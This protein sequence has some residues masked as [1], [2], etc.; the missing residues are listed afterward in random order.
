ML[1]ELLRRAFR[2]AP[3]PLARRLERAAAL[4]REKRLSEA[5]EQYEAVLESEPDNLVAHNNLANCLTWLGR[6]AEALPH[7]RRVCELHPSGIEA[8]S[9]VLGSLNYDASITPQQVFEAHRDWGRRVMALRASPLQHSRDRATGT[10]LRVGYVSPDLKRHPVTY[11]FAPTLAHHDHSRFEIFCYSNAAAG[12]DVTARL[13]RLSDHWHDVSGLTDEQ[14]RDQVLADRVD[15]LVD[16]AGH[17]ARTRLPAFAFKPAPVQVSWL[18]YF[19]TTGLET[20]D[21]FVTDEHSSPPGQERYFTER[22][23]RLPDTRFCYEP[24]QY[25]PE[26]SALPAL[27]A[28][29]VTFGCFNNVSKLNDRVMRLWARVLAAVP[30]SRLELRSIG[31]H[32]AA[33]VQHVRRR[34]AAH[35]VAGDRLDLSRYVGHA[36]LLA[37]YAGVDIALD[38]FPFCGG[39]TSLEALWMGVPPVTLEQPTI[40]GRQTLCFLRNIG[41]DELVAA[42]EDDYVG[43]AQR[44]ASDLD[45]LAQ[46]RAELRSRIAASPLM[47]A[48]AFTRQLEAAYEQMWDAA[49]GV[50][51]AKAWVQNTGTGFPPSRE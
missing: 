31:L 22:L 10:R 28:G 41:L 15:L 50:T 2:P 8:H 13:Q 36:P 25:A 20:I 40:A 42:S 48:A 46:L 27:R 26:V 24:P 38:P 3:V 37:A 45:A 12:D 11:L 4:E 17:T 30:G 23:V 6:A 18:G 21:Y 29:H 33:N 14:F 49:K 32:D 16:L 43:I 5:V 34:F 35:G 39:M 44:L 9:T 47:D 19:N 51:P 1:L 7:Y